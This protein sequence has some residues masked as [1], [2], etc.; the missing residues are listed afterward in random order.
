MSDTRPADRTHHRGAPPIDARYGRPRGAD[1]AGCGGSGEA[2]M[3]RR[4]KQMIA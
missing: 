4:A 2:G 1:L 3:T